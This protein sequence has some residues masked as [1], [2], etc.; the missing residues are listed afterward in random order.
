[1]VREVL[2]ALGVESDGSYIDCTVGEGGHAATIMAAVE[3]A[4]R[5]LGIDLDA[6]ALAVAG[7]RLGTYGERARLAQG[8]F[9]DLYRL[10]D[11]N[12][13]LPASGILLDLGMSMLQLQSAERGFS[14]SRAGPLDMRFDTAQELTAEHLVKDQTEEGLAEIIHELGEEP[15]ARRLARAIVRARPLRDTV[16]LAEIIRRAAG[17]SGGGRIHPATRTF[18]ALRMAVNRELHNL[19]DGLEQAVRVLGPGGRLVVISYHSLEDRLVKRTLKRE[20]SDCICPPAIPVC[21]CGHR[22]SIRLV[23]RRVTRPSPEE[24]RA[25]P[26]SRS[27]RMRVAASL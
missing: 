21:V 16:E 1:L 13:M 7:K 14:F 3:P 9:A 26:S 6:E 2:N 25:N 17:R 27:A 20:S 10:A 23:T 5:L 8:N 22:A 4:P 18:Q 19:R 12:G 15:K 24:V 11:E